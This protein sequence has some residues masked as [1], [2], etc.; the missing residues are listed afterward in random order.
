MVSELRT[1]VTGYGLRLSQFG[2]GLV[3]LA[4]QPFGKFFHRLIC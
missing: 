1:R 2:S 4:M 3:N